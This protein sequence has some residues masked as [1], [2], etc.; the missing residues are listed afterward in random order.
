MPDLILFVNKE[1]E[2]QVNELLPLLGPVLREATAKAL[3]GVEAG[4]VSVMV[5]PFTG[6][7]ATSMQILGIAS[8]TPDRLPRLHVWGVDLA[9]AWVKF[10]LI[11]DI[12]W[13]EDVDVW[14]TM[15]Y[16][17]WLMGSLGGLL[18]AADQLK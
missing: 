12:S 3:P 15:P 7:N 2:E 13:G 9:G 1:I 17:F 14:P 10:Q 4:D 8:A 18:K 11:N 6:E 16:G 5:V